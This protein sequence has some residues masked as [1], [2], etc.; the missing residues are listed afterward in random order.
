MDQ[1]STND[2][3]LEKENEDRKR[4]VVVWGLGVTFLTN[5][6]WEFREMM[7]IF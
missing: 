3:C 2:K 4:P 6:P 1:D 7:D 5:K